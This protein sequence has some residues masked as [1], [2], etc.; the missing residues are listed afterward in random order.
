V[1]PDTLAAAGAFRVGLAVT[2]HQA[3]DIRNQSGE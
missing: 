1:D 3:E 2:A